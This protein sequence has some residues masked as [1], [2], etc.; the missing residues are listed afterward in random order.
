M[1]HLTAGVLLIGFLMAADPTSRAGREQSS[2][3]RPIPKPTYGVLYNYDSGPV[4]EGK[5]P[6]RPA[7]VEQMVD[8][9]YARRPLAGFPSL[10]SFL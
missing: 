3:A 7:H 10:Q 1:M 4:F 9:R 6:T 5:G 8:E 2:R